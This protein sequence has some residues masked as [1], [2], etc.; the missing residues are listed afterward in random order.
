MGRS[1]GRPTKTDWDLLRRE[2]VRGCSLADL[3]IKFGV[4]I[5]TIQQRAWR[6]DWKELVKAA[7]STANRAIEEI[8][9]TQ[10]K[11]I[12][13][14]IADEVNRWQERVKDLNS[15]VLTKV[16]EL[17]PSIDKMDSAA[18]ATSAI[19][20]ADTTVRRALGLDNG[21][22]KG[23]RVNLTLTGRIDDLLSGQAAKPANVQVIDA[24]PGP[25]MDYREGSA[26]QV[27]DIAASPAS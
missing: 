6:E 7:R 12:Q 10:R 8:L 24:T 5:G 14:T 3:S 9:S 19:A 13:D 20:T 21:E 23:V 15:Q 17:I 4:A 1:V 22:D 25:A 27:L 26:K 18:K 2:Y 16:E 11:V